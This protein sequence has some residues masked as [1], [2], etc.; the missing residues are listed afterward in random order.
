MKFWGMLIIVSFMGE[1]NAATVEV[2]EVK[3]DNLGNGGGHSHFDES[4]QNEDPLKDAKPEFSTFLKENTALPK[5]Q[6]DIEKPEPYLLIMTEKDKLSPPGGG[7][8]HLDPDAINPKDL[9]SPEVPW[10]ENWWNGITSW[11]F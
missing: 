6:E 10:W 2:L 3:E 7:L 8:P 11:L 9:P 4:S 5:A 1:L